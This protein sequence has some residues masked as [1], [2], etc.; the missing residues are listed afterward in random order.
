MDIEAYRVKL[1][2]T[3]HCRRELLLPRRIDSEI[4]CEQSLIFLKFALAEIR[5]RHILREKTDCKQSSSERTAIFVTFVENSFHVT[6]SPNS[7]C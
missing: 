5:T 3:L 1:K 2:N 4:V 7:E 6:P